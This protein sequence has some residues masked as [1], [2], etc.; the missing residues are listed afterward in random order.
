MRNFSGMMCIRVEKEAHGEA[1]EGISELKG[2]F[3]LAF[4]G[5]I[6]K[7]AFISNISSEV[8]E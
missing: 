3:F 5:S 4:N 2:R 7:E 1:Q 8:T 6:D